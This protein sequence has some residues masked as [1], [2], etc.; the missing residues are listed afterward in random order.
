MERVCSL[1]F[2]V[3]TSKQVNAQFKSDIKVKTTDRIVMNSDWKENIKRVRGPEEDNMAIHQLLPTAIHGRVMYYFHPEHKETGKIWVIVGTDV[4]DK[5][6][7]A[8]NAIEKFIYD[9]MMKR[10]YFPPIWNRAKSVKQWF[11]SGCGYY[12]EAFLGN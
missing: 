6:S 5:T 7:V 1:G 2:H 12:C 10:D 9:E 3:W 4:L 11:D 8:A